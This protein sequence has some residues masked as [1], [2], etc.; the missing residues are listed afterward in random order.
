MLTLLSATDR[1]RP[2]NFVTCLLSVAV[3][4]LQEWCIGG[5][6]HPVSSLEL[7]E[8]NRVLPMKLQACQTYSSLEKALDMV[9]KFKI[10]SEFAGKELSSPAFTSVCV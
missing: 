4:N 3:H 1:A 9:D 8:V 10:V 2:M 7:V 5:M 6:I